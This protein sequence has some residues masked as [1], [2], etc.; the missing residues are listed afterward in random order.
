M[1]LKQKISCVSTDDNFFSS[2]I[3]QC[4]MFCQVKHIMF[5]NVWKIYS[6]V[7]GSKGLQSNK[8]ARVSMLW[9]RTH[10]AAKF[11]ILKTQFSLG[12]QGKT[13]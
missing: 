9:D 11:I 12:L 13:S 7:G 8:I 5:K 2:V 6:C 4:D 1:S 3:T 10:C